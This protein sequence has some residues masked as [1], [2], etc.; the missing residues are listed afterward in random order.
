MNTKNLNK[1][2]Y[3]LLVAV[4]TMI[5]I[6]INGSCSADED[7]WGFDEEYTS[8]ENT[9]SE[10]KDMSEYLTLSSKNIKE[11]TQKDYLNFGI[12]ADRMGVSFVNG[13]YVFKALR[14]KDINVSD[15]LIDVVKDLFGYTNTIL[16]ANMSNSNIPREKIRSPEMIYLLPNCVP[17]AVSKMEDS[18]RVPPY[19]AIEAACD[20]RFIGWR[21]NGGVPTEEVEG[22]V[23]I[24]TRVDTYDHLGFC[25]SDTTKLYHCVMQINRS[26]NNH[27]VN[28][29]ECVKI[30][31]SKTVFYYDYS[32]SGLPTGK[33]G[34]IS[35]GE[36]YEIY[37]LKNPK[38]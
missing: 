6:T 37:R 35:E 2:I 16:N 18:T 14:G 33:P 5:G 17:M 3:A 10:V 7:F 27:A 22:F 12:A 28:A 30:G 29:I 15:S 21:E 38:I 34:T 13:K 19:E 1:G 23:K 4:A 8:T 26:P 31:N 9:R 20:A 24:Y 36:L 32:T 25:T 11:W